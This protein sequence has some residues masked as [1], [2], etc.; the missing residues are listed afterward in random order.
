MKI[1][2]D[3]RLMKYMILFENLT[4]VKVKDIYA[5]GE[6]LWFVIEKGGMFKAIGKNGS[7]VKKVEDMIK[8]K[9]KLI[10]YDSDVCKFCVGMIYPVKA[11][12]IELKDDDLIITC[13]DFKS[14]GLLIGRERKNLKELKEVLLRYFKIGDIIVK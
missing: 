10:E 12:N 7:K 2:Y 5:R 4:R 9:I 8:K 14:K 3:Q 6:S 1:V 11:K 13:E